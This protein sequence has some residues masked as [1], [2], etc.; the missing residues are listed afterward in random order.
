MTHQK[1]AKQALANDLE[2]EEGETERG[3]WS[4]KLDFLLSC[5]GYAVGLGNVWRFPA[6][7]YKNGGGAFLI[8]YAIFLFVAGM[9]L[10]FMELGIGQFSSLGPVEAFGHLCPM[11]QGIGVGMVIISAIVCIYYNMIIAWTFFYTFASFQ[12]VLPWSNCNFKGSTSG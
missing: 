1:D 2:G 7:C 11:L 12:K 8:P 9:P 5:L 10:F 4:N 6:L 3:N